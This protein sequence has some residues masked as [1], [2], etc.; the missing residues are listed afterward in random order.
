MSCF[1]T[2]RRP[3]RCG[4][5]RSPRTASSPDQTAPVPAVCPLIAS[6]DRVPRA[7]VAP[8]DAAP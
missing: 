4:G 3:P 2:G 7:A 8:L 1:A 6:E 5:R